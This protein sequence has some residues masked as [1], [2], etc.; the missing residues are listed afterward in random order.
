MSLSQDIAS[1]AVPKGKVAIFW[2]GQAG[3]LFKTHEGIQIAIDPYLTN[4][5]EAMRGFKRLSPMLI[6]PE[7]LSPN[8]Y[9][10]THIHFDHFDFEAI[11]VIAKNDKTTFLGPTTCLAEFDKFGIDKNRCKELSRG[12]KHKLSDNIS[13]TA[14]VADHGAMAPDA[15]GI[16]LEI[17]GNVIYIGGDTCYRQDIFDEVAKQNPSIAILSINGEFGNMTAEEGAKAAKQLGVSVAI[18]CHFWTFFQHKG[19][20][21]E[22]YEI[23][24]NDE[25]C[26]PIFMRHGE[27]IVL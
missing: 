18:P 6:S 1:V 26:K 16:L 4:C 8:Y 19:K 23:L 12:M 22:F 10:A 2:L 15:I 13:I 21:H 20:P 9:I 7:E 11:P 3:F 5:G 17:D 27:N 24:S 25:K 14:I